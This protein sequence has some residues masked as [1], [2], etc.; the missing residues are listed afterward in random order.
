MVLEVIQDHDPSL[1]PSMIAEMG[2]EVISWIKEGNV[3]ED[4]DASEMEEF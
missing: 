1:L 2:P 3:L 4:L